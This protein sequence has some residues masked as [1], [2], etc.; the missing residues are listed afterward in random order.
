MQN[1]AIL[2]RH[3]PKQNFLI[4]LA[5]TKTTMPASKK[6]EVLE[7]LPPYGP[8]YVSVGEDNE[9]FFSE[10]FVVRFFKSNG[11]TWV[12]N[13]K[14]G[15]TNFTTVFELPEDKIV[16]IAY[17]LGY[18]MTTDQTKPVQTFGWGITEILPT[19]DNR[20]VAVDATNLIVINADG[21]IW[22]SPRISWDGITSLT[23]NGKIVSGLSY[24][25]MNDL[26]EWVPFY[27]NIDTK[28]IEEGSY[29]RYYDDNG[30][31]KKKPFWKFW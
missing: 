15:W 24:D 6:Y 8:M 27:L 12:G 17:G 18:I 14:K 26:N 19:L 4:S 22:E 20:F 21:T 31:Y 5:G 25:P 7:G 29:R 16:V 23:L 2:F 11:S 30:T 9:P 1:E 3:K 10:G 28:M 13:F